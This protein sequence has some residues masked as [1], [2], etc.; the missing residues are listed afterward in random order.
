MSDFTD[1]ASCNAQ[2][3]FANKVVGFKIKPFVFS[4]HGKSEAK[5]T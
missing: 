1:T 4:S 5:Q 3:F 2:S